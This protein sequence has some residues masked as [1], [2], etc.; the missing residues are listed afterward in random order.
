MMLGEWPVILPDYRVEHCAAQP[1]WEEG[2]LLSMHAHLKPGM[3]LY[4]VGAEHGDLSALYGTWL[5]GCTDRT[6]PCQDGDAC[7]YADYPDS[8]ALPTPS[9]WHRGGVV[10][11]EGSESFWPVIRATFEANGLTPIGCWA[12]FASDHDTPESGATPS[13][14]DP[15]LTVG[16][17]WPG[18]AGLSL[19]G[20]HPTPHHGFKS[21]VESK[22]TIPNLR[23][24]TLAEHV[25]PPDAL[26]IDVEG[27]EA[28][29][30][31][32]SERIL[33]EA[34][35][36]VWVSLHPQLLWFDYPEWEG[37]TADEVKPWF[38]DFM[39]GYGYGAHFIEDNHESHYLC[40][41]EER[42]DIDPRAG[43]E[44]LL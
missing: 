4:D 19:A 29:V 17:N 21:V 13:W 24:D 15:R 34:R 1:N 38:V 5:R 2:R 27:A 44:H 18:W 41:P 36:L 33:A 42:T 26:T 6:C 3:V 8:P 7:H 28:L 12:G 43:I 20:G 22:D 10:L 39:A 32:G 35:P 14:S 40:I 9:G 23:F 16:N 30:L 25:G 37:M 11:V 31:R